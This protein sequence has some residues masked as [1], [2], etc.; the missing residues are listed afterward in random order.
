M[1]TLLEWST[2]QKRIVDLVPQEVNPRKIS[3]KQMSDLKK[4]L[5]K[6]N[7]VEIPVIDTDGK[8]LAGHQRLKAM[9]LLGRGDEL[10]DCRVPNRKLSEDEAKRYLIA[11]NALGGTWDFDLLKSFDTP[12]LLDIGFD[13]IELSKL[14]D[15]DK[16]VVEDDIDVEKE[17]KKNKNPVVKLGDTVLL[18]SHKILCGDSTKKENLQKLFGGDRSSMIYS[19]PVYNLNVDYA[20][21]IGGD[22]DYGG[23]VNDARSFTE[24]HKFIKDSLEAGLLVSHPDTHVFYYCDQVYI[25]MIQQIYR[26]VRLVNKRVCLWLKNNQN[27]TPGV[28][29]NKVYEPCIYSVRKNPYLAEDMTKYNEVMNQELG[30][31]NELLEQVD[32]YIDIWTAKRLSGKEYEHATSKPI[33]LHE[34]A[35]KRCTRVGDIILDSFLGSGST[36]LCAEQLGRTVYGCE[37]EPVFCDLIIK[38]WEHMTGK[39][40]V[41]I[42]GDEKA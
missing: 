31:G 24:Y 16:K 27:P 40:A 2:I 10:I 35:I 15:E 23:E 3:D 5:K 36:L 17:I 14:M 13:S 25:G 11:S 4:S 41:I 38:R 7:L 18:G 19:D 22:G 42:S 9:Q 8:I 32:S 29:F 34:K 30:T 37:L 28:A 33:T 21:G 6:F 12:L 20:G 26:D 1:E 39:K